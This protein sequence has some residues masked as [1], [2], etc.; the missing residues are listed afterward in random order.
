MIHFDFKQSKLA[1]LI[2]SQSQ[3][4][5][6][7]VHF[8]TISDTLPPSRDTCIILFQVHG[9]LDNLTIRCAP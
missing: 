3:A 7:M 4:V 8:L 1:A 2:E 6:H 9:H 5:W